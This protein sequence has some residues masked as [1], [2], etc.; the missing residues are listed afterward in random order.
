MRNI[1]FYAVGFLAGLLMAGSVVAQDAVR[2]IDVGAFTSVQSITDSP[3]APAT[4]VG[5][6]RSLANR[7]AA[8]KAAK[9][10]TKA[11][12]KAKVLKNGKAKATSSKSKQTQARQKTAKT[13]KGTSKKVT[14][15]TAFVKKVTN[16]TKKKK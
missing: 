5:S 8:A 7:A 4:D 16:K 3:I 2:G 14:A 6:A 10:K 1:T 12:V 9:T 13:A 15:K 11:K